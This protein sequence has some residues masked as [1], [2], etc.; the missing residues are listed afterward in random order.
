MLNY[1]WILKAFVASAIGVNLGIVIALNNSTLSYAMKLKLIGHFH[2]VAHL[3][4]QQFL[5][6]KD[7]K[8]TI[9]T[10]SSVAETTDEIDSNSPQK[11]DFDADDPAIYVHPEDPGKSFVITT[12][13][14]GGLRVY[15]LKGQLI[16]SVSPQNVRYNNVDIAYEVEYPS[17]MAGETATV[18]LAIASDRMNDTL[19]I[20][21]IN[22]NLGFSGQNPLEEITS[23]SVP[24]TIFGIDDGEATAYGLTAYTSNNDRKAHIFVSQSDGNKI[25]QLEIQSGL[26]AADELTIDAKII[27]TFG[28]PIPPHV[29]ANKAFVEGMV[30]DRETE[31]LYLAQENFGIWKIDLDSMDSIEEILKDSNNTVDLVNEIKPN[32]PLSAD[33]EGLTIYYDNNDSG[34]LIASSQGDSTF[35][36]YDR[37]GDNSYLGSFAVEGVKQTDGLDITSI[38][39]GKEYPTGMLIVQDGLNKVPQAN[40]NSSG[41]KTYDLKTNFKFVSVKDIFEHF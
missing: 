37:A 9:T 13:K 31:F 34:Y 5:A 26:G 36:I 35:A 20:F 28:V 3:Y 16:Q 25:A 2:N 30:V 6:A 23:V 8:L 32:S 1:A 14:K 40:S 12:F 11:L 29:V 7:P 15:D 17:Q 4:N 39:L 21:K 22:P 19:A 10:V 18:D 41:K 27:R 38:P 33:I 24:D